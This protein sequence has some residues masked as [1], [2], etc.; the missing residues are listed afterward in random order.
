LL[1]LQGIEIDEDR[2]LLIRGRTRL[3][4]TAPAAAAGLARLQPM[5]VEG[6]AAIDHLIQDLDAPADRAALAL[7]DLLIARGLLVDADVA[8]HV[9]GQAPG[10]P[11][12]VFWWDEGRAAAAA[13]AAVASFRAAVMGVNPIGRALWRALCD[14]GFTEVR[15][16]DYAPLRRAGVPTAG[17]EPFEAFA[18]APGEIDALIVCTDGGD[19]EAL[20]DW[21]AF[22]LDE[23]LA[24]LPVLLDG[25]RGQ[26]GPW[27][28]P[29]RSACFECAWRR[30]TAVEGE[31]PSA[32]ER[33][34]CAG[35]HAA[36]H[37]PAMAG[38]LGQAAAAEAHREAGGLVART[39]NAILHYDLE[40]GSLTRRPLLKAPFCPACGARRDAPSLREETEGPL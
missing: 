32:A 33:A 31:P 29:G 24:Y 20:R 40:D 23:G 1:G 9:E 7:A 2:L 10:G 16:I 38:L 12:A 37:L 8:D 11:E 13:Q 17:A 34:A 6:G 35:P 19:V 28:R 26:V 21:N 36:G 27:V 39:V 25:R 14:A 15:W 18:E 5:S 4:F 30:W 3:T 22:C